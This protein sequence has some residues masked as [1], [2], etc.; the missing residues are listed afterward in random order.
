VSDAVWLAVDG[1]RFSFVQLGAI[2]L[3]A[4]LDVA[5]RARDGAALIST[6]LLDAASSWARA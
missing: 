6:E 2:A 4:D 1:L 3:V 5:N